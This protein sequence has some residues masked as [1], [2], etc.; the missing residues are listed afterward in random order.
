MSDASRQ[1]PTRSRRAELAARGILP[2]EPAAVYTAA[3]CGILILL[4]ASGEDWF[5][6]WRNLFHQ[7]A[8]QP[9]DLSAIAASSRQLLL[10]AVG[11]LVGVSLLCGWGVGWMQRRLSPPAARRSDGS[12]PGSE[13]AAPSWFAGL[14]AAAAM[15]A[16]AVVTLL[17]STG[18]M[19]WPSL[20][21]WRFSEAAGGVLLACAA[22]DLFVCAALTTWRYLRFDREQAMSHAEVAE[23]RRAEEGAGAAKDEV[24]ARRAGGG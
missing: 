16:F 4:A 13:A 14:L 12:L 20:R 9:Y 7:A 15:L 18:W 21:A 19:Q 5:V 2:F 23:E 6:E 8:E 3:L 11:S 24:A 17:L 1:P 10:H 22:A